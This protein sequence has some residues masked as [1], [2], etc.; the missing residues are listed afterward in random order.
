MH[1]YLVA[2]K[3]VQDQAW[4]A[5]FHE[6][7]Q[8]DSAQTERGALAYL[9]RIA[10]RRS[11]CWVGVAHLD[12]AEREARRSLA[13]WRDCSDARYTLATVM[14]FTGRRPEAQRQL[15]TLLDLYP[16]D[17]SARALRDSLRSW[18][19]RRTREAGGAAR[20]PD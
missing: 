2:R 13:L 3:L 17:R 11:F 15:D 5:A 19:A 7:A 12:Q 8:A 16:G 18:E 9:G 4:P 6:L 10:G 1:H 20:R 14:S